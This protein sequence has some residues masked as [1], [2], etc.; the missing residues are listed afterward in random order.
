MA[1]LP[2]ATL[3]GAVGGSSGA[4]EKSVI[5]LKKELSFSDGMDHTVVVIGRAE[6]I[7]SYAGKNG[8]SWGDV[9]VNRLD[10]FDSVS[11]MYYELDADDCNYWIVPGTWVEDAD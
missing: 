6:M 7:V 10:D 4:V 8:V 5:Y 1:A 11:G 9:I 3:A 2:S